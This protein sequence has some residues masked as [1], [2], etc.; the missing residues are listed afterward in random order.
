MAD[1]REEFIVRLDRDV[2]ELKDRAQEYQDAYHSL[3]VRVA[4]GL[5]LIDEGGLLS[6]AEQRGLMRIAS[7]RLLRGPI[8]GPI[9]MLG[10]RSSA[11]REPA[12]PSDQTGR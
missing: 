1:D 5:P 11:S 7:R 4:E 3:S 6:P 8:L 12:R 2:Q 10:H 9:G